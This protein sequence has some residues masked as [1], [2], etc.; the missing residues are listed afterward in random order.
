M[1]ANE[2]MVELN[3]RADG[4]QK[5]LKKE[6]AE[7]QHDQFHLIEGTTERVYWHYGYMVALIDVLNLIEKINR[8]RN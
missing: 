6:K 2:L 1:S 7:C 4:I 8:R 3:K 5:W